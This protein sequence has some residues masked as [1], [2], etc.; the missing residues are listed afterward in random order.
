MRRIRSLAAVCILSLVL[1][2][3]SL[4]GSPLLDAQLL[5]QGNLD[6]VYLNQPSEDYLQ[7]VSSTE[8]EARQDYE[9]GI[10]VEVD[11]AAS[12]FYIDLELC[13]ESISQRLYDLLCSIYTY[14]SYQ[15]GEAAETETG[16][17]VDVTVNPMDI[18][19]KMLEEDYD[20]AYEEI[21]AQQDFTSATEEEYETAWA[22][23]ILELLEARL[24]NI[25]YLEAVTV[26]VHVEQNDE[27]YYAIADED[28]S[29]VDWYI[30]SYGD[31]E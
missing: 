29:Q 23:F 9:D 15:V 6:V 27:G 1:G 18:F 17:V 8:E 13:D 22:E 20:D 21:W 7:L 28:F 3:C 14:S 24:D 4:F 10:W 19:Q 5:V 31:G 16:Y 26:S 30:L 2:G 25:G 11:A 12:Y